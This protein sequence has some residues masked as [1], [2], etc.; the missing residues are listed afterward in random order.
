MMILFYF[1]SK[2]IKKQEER[3][4]FADFYDAVI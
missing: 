1:N 2:K 4:L 3:K